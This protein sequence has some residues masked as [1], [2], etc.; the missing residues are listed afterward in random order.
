MPFKLM[1]F[2]VIHEYLACQHILSI[3]LFKKSN[4]IMK[5]RNEICTV[6]FP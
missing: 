4:P 2:S 5:L 6:P 3:S 1:V